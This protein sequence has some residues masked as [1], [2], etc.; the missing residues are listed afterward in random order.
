MDAD[1][2]RQTEEMFRRVGISYQKSWNGDI[3]EVEQLRERLAVANA[4]LMALTGKQDVRM[5]ELEL[6]WKEEDAQRAI[7]SAN[8]F[9]LMFGVACVLAFTSLLVADNL[10]QLVISLALTAGL[11]LATGLFLGKAAKGRKERTA[12]HRQRE[13]QAVLALMALEEEIESG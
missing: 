11:G 3:L 6:K 8:R 9:A 7:S 1:Q 12:A 2:L 10:Y 5:N 13:K 4:R